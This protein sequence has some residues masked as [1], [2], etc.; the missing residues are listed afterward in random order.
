MR[1]SVSR[2][3]PN[4]SISTPTAQARGGLLFAAKKRA[5]S[6]VRLMASVGAMGA[7]SRLSINGMAAPANGQ[8]L[9]DNNDTSVTVGGFGA[10]RGCDGSRSR[11]QQVEAERRRLVAPRPAQ[12]EACVGSKPGEL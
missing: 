6:V 5:K 12:G 3:K 11:R 10:R 7:A 2:V 4:S 9:S 1:S 8:L